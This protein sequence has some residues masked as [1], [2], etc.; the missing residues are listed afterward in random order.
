M[1][2]FIYLITFFLLISCSAETEQEILSKLNDISFGIPKEKVR[3]IPDGESLISIPVGNKKNLPLLLVFGGISY[4]NPQFMIEQIPSVFFE[5]SVIIT[6]PCTVQGGKGFRNYL[7]YFQKKLKKDGIIINKISV[8]G[9]SAGGPD[10]LNA[11]DASD[12]KIIGLIDPNP[13]ISSTKL[14]K[15][16]IITAYNK[17]NWHDNTEPLKQNMLNKFGDYAKWTKER[18]GIVEENSVQHIIFPKY[19]FYKYRNKLL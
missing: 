8:C 15:A 9:F 14:T 1:K 16:N 12:V 18:G 19:F 10:A 13:Y 2:I 4:A 7:N 17:N 11:V 6:V 3:L 5:K